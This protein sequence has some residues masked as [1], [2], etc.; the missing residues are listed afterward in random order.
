M[1][2]EG[3]ALRPEL[4]AYARAAYGWPADTAITPGPRGALGRIHRVAAGGTR[5]ALKEILAEPPTPARLA[6]ELALARRAA[7]AGVRLPA[8]H[9]D[10]SGRYLLT[11]PGGGWLRLYDWVDLRPLDPADPATPPLVG[12]LLARLHRCA[13]PA[14]AEPGGSAPAAWYH[15]PPDPADWAAVAGSRAEWGAR[16]AAVLPAVAEVAALATPVPAAGLL[17][18]HRDLHPENVLLDPSGTP[19][20]VDWDNLGPAAPARELAGVLFDWFCPA[21]GP[22]LAAMRSAYAAYAAAGG[23][24]RIRGAADFSM[25]VATRLNFL[26]V[27]ARA[28]LDPAGPAG[29][30]AWAEREIDEGLALLPGPRQVEAVL[31]GVRRST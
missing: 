26:L 5:Y 13:P 15:R 27:Q 31:A 4:A 23:P 30:R 17:L 19:V 21:G 1:D 8:S 25:L 20:V 6:A 2:P 22:D 9:P 12:E 10:R 3:P 29:Q 18:C 14:A 11:A 24:G 16:L 28:W 7:A